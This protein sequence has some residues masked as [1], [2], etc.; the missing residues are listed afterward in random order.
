MEKTIAKLDIK[1]ILDY[2]VTTYALCLDNP[3][4]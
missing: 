1:N 2:F 3:L 4:Y